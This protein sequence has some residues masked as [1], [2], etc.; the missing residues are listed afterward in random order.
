M[1]TGKRLQIVCSACGA[2][3][4]LKREPLYEGLRKVGE[5]LQCGDCGHVY[6]DDEAIPYKDTAGP[7]IFTAADRSPDVKVFE[8]DATGHNCRHCRH[9]VVNPFLQRCGLHHIEVQATDVCD[10]FAAKDENDTDDPLARLIRP[11]G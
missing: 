11:P 9:Y 5:R 4:F 6:A 10:D 7:R 2:D 8:G 1:P 3:T